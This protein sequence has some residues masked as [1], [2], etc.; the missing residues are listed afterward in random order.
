MPNYK[1]REYFKNNYRT[2]EST[3]SEKEHEISKS[4]L[5]IA[6]FG[7]YTAVI[8]AIASFVAI[9]VAIYSLGIPATVK[10][11]SDQVK[12]IKESIQKTEKHSEKDTIYIKK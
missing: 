7:L 11:N 6:K 1:L 2:P 10:I 3:L 5:R 8:S 9:V 4:N 12:E